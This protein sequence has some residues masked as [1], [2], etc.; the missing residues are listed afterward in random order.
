MI[1]E[2]KLV[3]VGLPVVK[4]QFF[5]QALE[6]CL[7][8]SHFNIEII[9]QN[10]AFDVITKQG[11]KE[12]VDIFVDNR[13]K[14]FET[15]HQ[16]SMV[17]NWNN[18]LEKVSGTF[19]AILCDDDKWHPDFI[20]EMISLS[21]KFPETNIFHSRVLTIDENEVEKNLSPLCPIFE[22]GLDFIYHRIAGLR[23]MYLSDFMVRTTAIKSIGGFTELP[24]GWGSDDI[25]WF[26]IALNGGVAYSS[27]ELF[28]YRDSMI[29]TSNN[30]NIKNK[31]L[32]IDYQYN[33]IVKM[34]SNG[35]YEKNL[36]YKIIREYLGKYKDTKK[37]TLWSKLL[38]NK[39]LLPIS[40]SNIIA[41][42]YRYY[43]RKLNK[44]KTIS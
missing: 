25:T 19:F 15:E 42:G 20:K 39:Y 9:I 21:E 8:Q 11:I 2:S 35:T 13:I 14:Y 16:I 12:I 1:S 7:N 6:S 5:K 3:S 22:D 10:N 26:K 31:L 33:E 34:I 32:A 30:K 23:S 17:E 41:L 28:Y 27:K 36:K 29:N 44:K 24:D 37:Y 4:K 18:I 40:I 43:S 38:Q